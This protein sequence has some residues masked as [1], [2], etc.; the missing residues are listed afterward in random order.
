MSRTS[1]LV[2]RDRP[3]S[4]L[5]GVL[6]AA[7]AV[8]LTTVLIYAIKQV[9][10]PVSTGVVYLVAVLL[11]SMYWGVWLGPA[12]RAS[13]ARWRSTSS[14]SRP[15]GG[16]RSPRRRT[17]S[18][19]PCS[20]SRRGSRRAVAEVART[21]RGGR[22]RRREADLAAEMARA[23]ARR[24]DARRR[25]AGRR[26]AARAGARPRRRR[27]SSSP[28]STADARRAACRSTSAA[29][30]SGRVLVP[31]ATD[32]GRARARRERVV[33]VARGAAG[34]G[35]RPRRAAGR[36]RRDAGAAALGRDQDRAAARGLARPAHAADGDH[37]RRHG[38]RARRASTGASARSSAR[39]SSRRR[40]GCRGSSTSCSTSRGCR[41]GERGAARATG[42]RSRRSCEPPSADVA[43]AAARPSRCRSTAT[44]RSCRPT[45]RSSSACS[46]TCSRTRA[47][48][49]AAQPVKVR[50]RV[51]GG[52]MIVR[53]ID[54]GPGIPPERLERIFEPFYRDDERRAHPG[55]GLGLA[56][57]RG[58]VE[59]NGGRVWAE[60]LPGQGT[61]FVVELPLP[62]PRSRRRGSGRGGLAVSAAPPAGRV[63]VC[64]DELQILRALKVVLREAGFEV[65]AAPTAPGGARRRRGAAARRRDRR[66]HAARRRR[67]R[68]LP[69]A[70]RVERDADPRAVR[71]RRR[72]RRR[73]A[74]SRRGPTTTS[75]SRSG[76]ASSSRACARCC[77]ARGPGPTTSRLI[78]VDGLE[79]DLAAHV[80]RRDGAGGP[81]HAD[82]VRPAAGAGAQPRAAADAPRRC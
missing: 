76:R 32:A 43:A 56:I 67:R 64:D 9:A 62:A 5:L 28:R 80:V 66:P 61:A 37:D 2:L 38:A 35:A 47:A 6:C 52:R 78:A 36:G 48:T 26:A 57:V 14:T 4:R 34:R 23:P 65:E 21:R 50:A 40:S 8:A 51:G 53:V 54:R 63:L 17:G 68:G 58:F 49:P 7:A 44:C 24:R 29:S 10:P 18:R 79:I 73:C 20:S 41:R 82:R 12:D 69:A 55:S 70:A 45:P 30:G 3:P 77:A 71:A 75:P 81:P 59:A 27:R 60:S 13:R 11:V 16:S 15:P 46:S 22:A 72:G 1:L 25:A 74:R 19:W 31:S 33:A 39:S 42:A